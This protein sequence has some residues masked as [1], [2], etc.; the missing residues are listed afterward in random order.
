MVRYFVM[1]LGVPSN[2]GWQRSRRTQVCKSQMV[3]GAVWLDQVSP[4]RTKRTLMSN[5]RIT[6]L[7]VQNL[8]V[9]WGRLGFND[10]SSEGQGSVYEEIGVMWPN[11]NLWARYNYG[12]AET[13][14]RQLDMRTLVAGELNIVYK[15]GVSLREKEARLR[16]LR[17]VKFYSAHYQWPALLKWWGWGVRVVGLGVGGWGWGSVKT[18]D[19]SLGKGR[20]DRRAKKGPKLVRRLPMLGA[21]MRTGCFIVLNTRTMLVIFTTII[22][23]GRGI[24]KSC[25]VSKHLCCL[26]G[27]IKVEGTAP[28]LFH[29]VPSLRTVT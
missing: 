15:C 16:L 13:K 14:F 6:V 12:E 19:V 8:L 5:Y 9:G 27:K 10:V 18:N 3:Q 4:G 1:L 7:N 20:S 28:N 23:G 29:G 26:L 11:E 21:K 17:V 22:G 24:W 25:I 2:V